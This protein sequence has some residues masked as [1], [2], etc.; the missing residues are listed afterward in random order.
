[1]SLRA[2][3]HASDFRLQCVTVSVRLTHMI[4]DPHHCAYFHI[5]YLMRKARF[6]AQ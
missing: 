6:K 5:N 2:D 4:L 1:M 3:F